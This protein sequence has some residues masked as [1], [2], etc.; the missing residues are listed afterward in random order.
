MKICFSFFE[1]VPLKKF[2]IKGFFFLIKGKLFK[3]RR[4]KK[5]FIKKGNVSLINTKINIKHAK[6]FVITRQGSYSLNFWLSFE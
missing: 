4:K 6:Y 5:Y 2:D 3:K 1:N